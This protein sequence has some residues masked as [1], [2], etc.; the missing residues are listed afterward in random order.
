[1]PKLYRLWIN[2]EKWRSV[3]RAQKTGILGEPPNFKEAAHELSRRGF[4]AIVFGHTHHPGISE[5]EGGALYLNPGSWML[6]THYVLIEN[7]W[8]ELKE[9]EK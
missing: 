9:W 5:L 6:S 4:D 1:M 8:I 3:L 2:F 7:G